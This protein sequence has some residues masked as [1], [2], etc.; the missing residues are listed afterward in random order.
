MVSTVN[1][2]KSFN[3]YYCSCLQTTR[4]IVFHGFMGHYPPFGGKPN[5]F[6]I[7]YFE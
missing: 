4:D 5:I 1:E 2:Y 6:D 3:N 7:V